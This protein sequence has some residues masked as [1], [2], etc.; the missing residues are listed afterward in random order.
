MADKKTMTLFNYIGGKTWLK[1]H[2]KKEVTQILSQK[3][4]THYVEPF[5]GGL[6]AFLG[7]YDT[8]LSNGINNVILNDINGKLINFYNVVQNKPEELIKEYIALEQKFLLTIPEEAK[9]FHKTK[10]KI[11]LKTILKN[12]EQYYK[13]VRSN[14][15][16]VQTEIESAITLLFL[17]NHCFNGIYRENSKGGYNTP[18]NWEARVYTEDKV[19]EKI[20]AVHT[21]FKKFNIEFSNKSFQDLAFNDYTL[22]Y[23]DPPY[24][25][26]VEAL[27][28]QYHKDS[29]DVEK[30]K[31][32]IKTIKNSSFIYSN[33][34]NPVLIEEFTNN[35]IN[36]EVK[37]IPRKNIISASNESRQTDK[38]EILV[39]SK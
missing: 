34:D 30:Q 20:M 17:Q 35:G 33:H 10:D 26:E 7:V 39:S 6:G 12:A 2:L 24:I 9:T 16:E 18:F 14:Y 22:Y 23:L 31:D 25:N 32:L 4:L 29:F 19:R 28:N 5:A 27:E 38:V 1:E 13:Q 36:I 21:L 3:K 11:I 37:R 15:N 8:L